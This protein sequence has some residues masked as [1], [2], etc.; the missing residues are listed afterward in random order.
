MT[1]DPLTPAQIAE[2]E[3]IARSARINYL[4]ILPFLQELKA[5]GYRIVRDADGDQ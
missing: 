3:Q 2:I 5:R 1:A 4:G